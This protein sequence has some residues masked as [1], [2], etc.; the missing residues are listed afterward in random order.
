MSRPAF[1]QRPELWT[2]TPRTIQSAV[3]QAC[4]VEHNVSPISTTE[5]VAGVILAVVLGIVFAA[6]LWHGM[7]S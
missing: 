3:D 7:A 4:A 5:R 6:L 1:L 2:R